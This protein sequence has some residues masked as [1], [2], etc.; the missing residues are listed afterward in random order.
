MKNFVQTICIFVPRARKPIHELRHRYA[1]KI[2]VIVGYATF[3]KTWKVMHKLNLLLGPN[4]IF[5]TTGI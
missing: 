1:P 5:D 2:R 3:N 4:R